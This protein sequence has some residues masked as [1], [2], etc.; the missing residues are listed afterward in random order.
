MRAVEVGGGGGGGEG[1]APGPEVLPD[2][3]I[4]KDPAVH[5]PDADRVARE[6]RRLVEGEVAFQA[7]EL[8]KDADID[9]MVKEI[10][11]IGE[12]CATAE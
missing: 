8:R 12:E 7:A 1:G 2:H 6:A 11:A 10:T 9:R 3:G 4:G 5:S